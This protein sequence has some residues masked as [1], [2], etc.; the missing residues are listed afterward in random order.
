MRTIDKHVPS[1]GRKLD[2]HPFHL[3]CNVDLAPK[4][5]GIRQAKSHVEHVVLVVTRFLKEIVVL[6]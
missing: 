4:T 1:C 3:L 5:R 6:R 2:V